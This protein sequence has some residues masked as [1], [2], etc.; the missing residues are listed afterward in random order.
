VI[1]PPAKKLPSTFEY[2]VKNDET[3]RLAGKVYRRNRPAGK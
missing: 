2:T 1:T 3:L